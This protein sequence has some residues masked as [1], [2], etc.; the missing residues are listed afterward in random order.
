MRNG[1]LAIPPRDAAEAAELAREARELG[2]P[3]V[4]EDFANEAVHLARKELE[5]NVLVAL[6]GG[7]HSGT[8][9]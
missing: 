2:L 1:V 7:Q 9:H 3:A 8:I 5:Q 6:F 4:A